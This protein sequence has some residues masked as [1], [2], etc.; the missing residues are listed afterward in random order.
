MPT[1]RCRSGRTRQRARRERKEIATVASL[2]AA[3]LLL[4]GGY[5]WLLGGTAPPRPAPAI[6]GPFALTTGSGQAVTD[7]SF[8]GRYLLIYFGYTACRDVCP[9]TLAAMGQALDALGNRGNQVQPLFVTVDPR[10]DTPDVVQRYVAAFSPRLVGLT[11]T[12]KQVEAV[13]REYR[14][15]AAIHDDHASAQG[16]AVDHSS[17][18]YLVAPDGRYLAPIRANETSAEIAADVARH[19]S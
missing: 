16:Y 2:A 9:L 15:S 18:L 5:L 8:R 4:A 3:L 10:R 1:C 14:V 12:P 6:G 13:A 7:A 17:V 11:G 19:L